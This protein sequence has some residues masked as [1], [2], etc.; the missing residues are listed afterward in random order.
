MP[1]TDKYKSPIYPKTPYYNE[2]EQT[3]TRLDFSKANLEVG[4][5]IDTTSLNSIKDLKRFYTDNYGTPK[6]VAANERYRERHNLSSYFDP[7]GMN[8]QERAE[9]NLIDQAHRERFQKDYFN[10]YPPT[11]ESSTTNVARPAVPEMKAGGLMKNNIQKYNKGG[12]IA[13][14]FAETGVGKFVD[15][16]GNS[17]GFGIASSVYGTI[18]DYADY[19]ELNKAAFK[20]VENTDYYTEA[21]FDINKMTTSAGDIHRLEHEDVAGRYEVDEKTIRGLAKQARKEKGEAIGGTVGTIAGTLLGS[22]SAGN[23]VGRQL[24]KVF[25]GIRG[26][27]Y[28]RKIQNRINAEYAKAEKD[29]KEYLGKRSNLFEKR[30]LGLIRGQQIEAKKEQ[31]SNM[32]SY[33]DSLQGDISYLKYGGT[34]DGVVK[35]PSHEEGGVMAT[36]NGKPVAEIEGEEYVTNAK[37]TKNSPESKNTYAVQGTP[38]QILSALNSVNN[39]GDATHPGGKIN[40]IA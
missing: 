18:K 37:I 16:V 25:G 33:L 40:R 34:F 30:D 5:Y 14:K 9:F 8:N 4:S 20:D 3:P 32:Q 17:T 6:Q 11:F 19:R 27:K 36:K 35:G 7:Y 29:K 21:G 12:T 15:K 31:A 1:K 39:Y 2:K 38:L 22:P 10:F 24:G 28:K 13:D 26:K 23:W